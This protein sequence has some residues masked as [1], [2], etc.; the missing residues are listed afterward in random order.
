[1]EKL[2]KGFYFELAGAAQ[3]QIVLPRQ[4][5]HAVAGLVHRDAALVAAHQLVEIKV[6]VA[7]TH[8]AAIAGPPH[9]RP[10]VSNIEGCC[11]YN[12]CR[13]CAWLQS[14]LFLC[15]GSEEWL[16]KIRFLGWNGMHSI[17]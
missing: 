3:P 2:D 4:L 12:K 16:E 9:L 8:R 14:D 13:P 17:M 1:M 5:G 11:K 10:T 15:L 6:H 7:V